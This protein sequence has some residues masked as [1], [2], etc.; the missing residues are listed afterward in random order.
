MPVVVA[1]LV[2]AAAAPVRTLPPTIDVPTD[3]SG[4]YGT[5]ERS[6]I[7]Q[8]ATMPDVHC[9]ITLS[10]V[11]IAAYHSYL[12]SAMHCLNDEQPVDSCG[13]QQAGYQPASFHCSANGGTIYVNVPK[14]VQIFGAAHSGYLERNSGA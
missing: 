4:S 10:T 11:T 1:V 7:Y 3:D 5:P 9:G 13:N 14:M 8:T 12:K 6:A 2:G